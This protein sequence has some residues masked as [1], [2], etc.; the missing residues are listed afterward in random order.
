MT[1]SE[2]SL[3]LVIDGGKSKTHAAI[4]DEDGVELARSTG[5]GLAIIETPGG[6]GEVT[7]SL[8]ETIAG[9]GAQR[10]FHTACIGLNGVLRAGPK[11]T[12][13][14]LEALQEVCES[15]RYI[16]TSDV[17][18]SYLGALGISPG[19]VIAAGTG[20]VIL[21]LGEDGL[22][23]PVDGSGPLCG[24]RGSGYDIGRRGL[25]SALRVADGMQGSDLILAQVEKSFGGVSG[26]LSAMYTSQNPAKV[27][28]SFS[29][30][31][32]AAA[33]LG[34]ETAVAIWDNAARDLAEGAVAAARAAGLL[35]TPFTVATAGGLF[36]AGAV[37]WDSLARELSERA[38][39]ATL[40]Q[41]EGDALLG[42]TR[43]ALSEEPILTEVSTWADLGSTGHRGGERG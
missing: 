38:P 37:L 34:D 15:R 25:D 9:L 32:A 20:S 36:G 11:P 22:P 28:A 40:R 13:L 33:A 3:R 31:V 21:A 6:L 42:A 12:A 16:V 43:L 5:P 4:I 27:I 41:G 35:D 30:G 24:D 1:T 29:R 14:A 18:T 17:V 2:S 26:A 10:S 39:M 23:H 7:D 19:V 8:R